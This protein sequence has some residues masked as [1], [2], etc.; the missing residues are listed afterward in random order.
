[1]PKRSAIHRKIFQATVVQARFQH[2]KIHQKPPNLPRLI[3]RPPAVRHL[4][5][6]EVWA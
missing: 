5:A 4:R 3:A 6:T 2:Q 1:M